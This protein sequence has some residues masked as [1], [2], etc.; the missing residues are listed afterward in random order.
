MKIW[1][2]SMINQQIILKTHIQIK[3]NLLIKII[4]KKLKMDYTNLY[5][6]FKPFIM[7][8]LIESNH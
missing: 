5:N 1:N 7:T 3:F 2:V 4:D 6:C 8:N